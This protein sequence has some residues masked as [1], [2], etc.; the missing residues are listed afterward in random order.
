MR[1]VS[2]ARLTADLS[3]RGFLREVGHLT[4]TVAGS[5]VLASCSSPR[6]TAPGQGAAERNLGG[7]LNFLGIRRRRRHQCRQDFSGIE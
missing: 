6:T 3:R 4:L 5:C 1:D 7:V 2:G